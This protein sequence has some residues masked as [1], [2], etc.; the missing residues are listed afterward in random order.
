MATTDVSRI[1]TPQPRPVLR[2]LQRH[3]L[4]RIVLPIGLTVF[5][6]WTLFPYFWIVVTSIKPNRDIFVDSTIF[7]TQPPSIGWFSANEST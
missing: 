7:P 1:Q 3:A 4:H 6:L 5:I 2:W